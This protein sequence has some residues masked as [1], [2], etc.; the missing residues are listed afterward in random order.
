VNV[1]KALTT[2]RTFLLCQ[3]S[4]LGVTRSYFRFIH[5]AYLDLHIPEQT[6]GRCENYMKEGKEPGDAPIPS[7][8][9]R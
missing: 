6:E 7:V 8:R 9:Y 5:D 2:L 1:D 3:V 4:R